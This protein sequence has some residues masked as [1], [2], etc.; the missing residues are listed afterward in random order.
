MKKN[1]SITLKKTILSIFLVLILIVIF[2]LGYFTAWAEDSRVDISKIDQGYY[3]S[4]IYHTEKLNFEKTSY[5]KEEGNKHLNSI[6]GYRKVDKYEEN[7]KNY[8]QASIKAINE[9][10]N[11][12]EI[13]FDYNIISKEDKYF[14]VY[15]EDLDNNRDYFLSY[16]DIESNTLFQLDIP[17]EFEIYE[18]DK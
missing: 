17:R 1:K 15:S 9:A 2:L 4:E 14:V 7:I 8:I 5:N 13:E 12:I 18:I 16:Y 6:P 10:D 3:K 11:T